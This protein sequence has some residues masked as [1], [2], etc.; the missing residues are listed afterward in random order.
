MERSAAFGHITRKPSMMKDEMTDIEWYEHLPVVGELLEPLE[1]RKLAT[2]YGPTNIPTGY[3][4][5][6]IRGM[7]S[8]PVWARHHTDNSYILSSIFVIHSPSKRLLLV[9]ALYVGDYHL[10]TMFDL[11]N[12]FTRRMLEETKRFGMLRFL[13]DACDDTK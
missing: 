7:I 9:I 8:P 5:Y 10:R 6:A 3:S 13:L 1:Y 2:Y 12:R 11:E 4:G